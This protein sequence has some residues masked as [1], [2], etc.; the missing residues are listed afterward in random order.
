MG[1]LLLAAA[2]G[3]AGNVRLLG[4][5]P[6]SARIHPLRRP[7][8]ALLPCAHA[9]ILCLAPALDAPCMHSCRARTQ[10][11]SAWRP[12]WTPAG[13]DGYSKRFGTV[14]I[15]YTSPKLD[16]YYKG[17]SMWLSNHFGLTSIRSAPS[18][19][20][21]GSTGSPPA[22]AQPPAGGPGGAP[23]PAGGPPAGDAPPAKDGSGSS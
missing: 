16:R 15:D 17:S 23:A 12:P 11:S 6:S 3:R 20:S 9:S 18:A 21:T 1:G 2:P 14:Y 7:L 4:V 8:H 5:H 13:A 10:V 22:A 19:N